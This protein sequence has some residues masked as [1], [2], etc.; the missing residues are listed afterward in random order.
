M[1]KILQAMH[2]F[3]YFLYLFVFCIG[4]I[5]VLYRFK[6]INHLNNIVLS[7]KHYISN[8]L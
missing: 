2:L 4:C 7:Q 8:K 5:I 3:I 6:S 1:K